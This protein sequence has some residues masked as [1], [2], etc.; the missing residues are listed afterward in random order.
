MNFLLKKML[1]SQRFSP[2]ILFQNM[3]LLQKKK[4]PKGE[5]LKLHGKDGIRGVREEG[6][7]GARRED[8]V[9][10]AEQKRK[11]ANSPVS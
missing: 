8:I 1:S 7:S 2:T 4:N 5:K 9:E 10:K 11:W 6:Y 3:G